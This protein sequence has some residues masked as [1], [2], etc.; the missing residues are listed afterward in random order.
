MNLSPGWGVYEAQAPVHVTIPG[1]C[2][3]GDALDCAFV[4]EW[5]SEPRVDET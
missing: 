5:V 2:A 3:H 4:A 1:R